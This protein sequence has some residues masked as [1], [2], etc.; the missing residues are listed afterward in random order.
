MR[1][2]FTSTNGLGH[3]YPMLPLARAVQRAGHDIRFAVPGNIAGTVRQRGFDAAVTT[4]GEP[5]AETKELFERALS[6]VDPSVTV[7]RDYF[8]G[9]LVREGLEPMISIIRRV[10]PDVIVSENLEACGPLAAEHLG[11]PHVSLGTGP[12]GLADTSRA[13]L[14][15]GLDAHRRRLGLR[16][17]GDEK[18]L[19]RHL[20]TT[21]FPHFLQ[22]PD[23]V[24]PDFTMQFRHEDP[25]G[26]VQ[27]HPR[28]S[29]SGRPAVYAS[30]GTVAGGNDA[31]ADA[32]R[33]LLRGLG[34]ADADVLF[35][36]GRFDPAE[37]GS[38]PDNVT[39]ATR[40]SPAEA[41]ACDLVVT[42]AGAGTVTTALSRGLPMVALPLFAD[43]PS[44][45]GRVRDL[46]AGVVVSVAEAS[47]QLPEAIAQVATEPSYRASAR[48]LAGVIAASPSADFV[49]PR[50]AGLADLTAAA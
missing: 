2:L 47:E 29:H 32:H 7:L 11:I 17:T 41:M 20:F 8:A 36:I 26:V 22:A 16:P 24:L 42:H 13:A 44:N 40:L 3:L 50:L 14:A 45:A 21:P 10:Q 49:V 19:Y 9:T 27:T 5:S 43:Q 38:I 37:L 30:L 48:A 18:W 12:I 4:S 6:Q 39:L 28:W 34:R 31:M 35:T 46:G 23:T 25:E 33:A 1:T 15:E